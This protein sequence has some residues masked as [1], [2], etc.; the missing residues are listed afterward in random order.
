MG[1]GW[2]SNTCAL[3]VFV[4]KEDKEGTIAMQVA[5]IFETTHRLT[6]SNVFFPIVFRATILL[7]GADRIK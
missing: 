3:S 2:V 6:G 1:H 5:C 7:A 4:L